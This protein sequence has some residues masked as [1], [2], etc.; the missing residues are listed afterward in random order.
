MQKVLTRI[1]LNIYNTKVEIQTNRIKIVK[2]IIE[3]F[4]LRIQQD[5]QFLNGELR[6]AYKN[7][8]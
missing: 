5:I 4:K 1:F 7:N 2:A 6:D 3:K 8:E